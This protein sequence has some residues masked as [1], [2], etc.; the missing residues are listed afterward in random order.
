MGPEV[1][2]GGDLGRAQVLLAAAFAAAAVVV[3]AATSSSNRLGIALVAEGFRQPVQVVAAPGEPGRLYVVERAGRVRVVDHGRVLGRPFLDIRPRVRSGGLIGLL[4]I[5]FP[6]RYA[7][8][9]RLFAMFTEPGGSLVVQ[10]LRVRRG[11]ASPVRVIL[12]V[13]VPASL[14]AHVGG[15]LA[16]GPGGRLDASIGDGL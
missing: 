1:A 14:Y 12:R 3:P 4:S 7:T 5:A 16:F 8:E 10:E 15:Q 6:P 2:G 9:K 11:R 13:Q